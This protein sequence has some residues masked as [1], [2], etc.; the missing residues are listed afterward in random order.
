MIKFYGRLD[1][2]TG[3]LCNLTD[4][5]EGANYGWNMKTKRVAWMKFSGESNNFYGKKHTE[6]SKEKNRQKHLGK[7]LSRTK[8]IK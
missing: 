8:K 7:K 4:G 6:E 3:S 5:G 1:L 2:G